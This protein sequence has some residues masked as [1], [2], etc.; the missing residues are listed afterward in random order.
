MQSIRHPP[1]LAYGLKCP[2]VAV[3]THLRVTS[4]RP[5]VGLST[6]S[7]V[8]TRRSDVSANA[9][10]VASSGN[11]W[12]G[13]ETTTPSGALAAPLPREEPV[14]GH[15]DLQRLIAQI[16]FQKLAIWGLVGFVAYQLS[17]FFGVSVA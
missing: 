16:P 6:T 11:S 2:S 5:R 3:R 12:T 4:S 17:D 7:D 13:D 14:D 9:G 10:P 1:R 15:K 8:Y